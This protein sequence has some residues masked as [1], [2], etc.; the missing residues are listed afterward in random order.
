MLQSFK[1][2]EIHIV[3]ICLINQTKQI[4]KPSEEVFHA[5]MDT[6]AP[7]FFWNGGNQLTRLANKVLEFSFTQCPWQNFRVKDLP[8]ERYMIIFV[9]RY[10]SSVMSRVNGES[11]N[12]GRQPHQPDPAPIHVCNSHINDIR[13]RKIYK[14]WRS[15]KS[16]LWYWIFGEKSRLYKAK[17]RP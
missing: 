3:C 9:K 11:P 1:D 8:R 7:P 5:F 12:P 17:N 13:M 4:W 14:V 15:G 10:S 6:F 2:V 16:S